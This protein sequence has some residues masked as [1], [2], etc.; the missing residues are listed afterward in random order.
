[1]PTALRTAFALLA[2]STSIAAA[3]EAPAPRAARRA[4]VS[5][6]SEV[7]SARAGDDSKVL[8]ECLTEA[9][10]ACQAEY[11][12]ALRAAPSAPVVVSLR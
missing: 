11:T 2:L 8:R 12:A 7:C 3:N 1:M 4:C 9:V 10:V 5:V 6:G